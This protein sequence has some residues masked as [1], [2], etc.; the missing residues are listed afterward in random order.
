M[1]SRQAY[2]DVNDTV[3]AV[4]MCVYFTDAVFTAKIIIC[5]ADSMIVIML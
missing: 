2:V 3:I 1:L 4:K 5:F